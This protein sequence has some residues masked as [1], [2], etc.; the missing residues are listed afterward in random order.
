MGGGFVFWRLRFPLPLF[1][2]TRLLFAAAICGA[3]ARGVLTL[4]GGALSLLPAIAVGIV[5]YVAAVRLLRALHPDDAAQ[6]RKLCAVF[7]ARLR[8]GIAQA[9]D[10]LAPEPRPAAAFAA[11]R[12]H[13]SPG[14]AD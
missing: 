6:L 8:A 9:V 1:D 14:D 11:V 2:L 5:A 10:L 3:A 12:P 13:R 7:P 4:S